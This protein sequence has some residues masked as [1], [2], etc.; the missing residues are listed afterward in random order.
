MCIR[1]RNSRPENTIQNLEEAK[2][3]TTVVIR[4]SY[5]YHSLVKLGFNEET[6][7]YVVSSL[8]HGIALFLSGKVDLIFADP[9]VLTDFFAEQQ[10]NAQTLFS[11]LVLPETRRDSYI[12]ANINTESGILEKLKRAADKLR[13][14]PGYQYY[15]AYKALKED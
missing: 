11:V 14:D 1:D 8:K 2:S 4:D 15:L 10:Q 12:A 3:K 9:N 5:G 6:N 13:T 7:L